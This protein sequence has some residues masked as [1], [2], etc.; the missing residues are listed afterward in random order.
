LQVMDDA[1]GV[2]VKGLA[3]CLADGARAA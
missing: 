1:R 3:E 2:V